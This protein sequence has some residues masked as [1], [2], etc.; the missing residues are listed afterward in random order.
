MTRLIDNV[1]SALHHD[2]DEQLKK[3]WERAGRPPALRRAFGGQVLAFRASM[4]LPFFK[5]MNSFLHVFP[6]AEA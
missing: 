2:T 3:A 6:L 1:S 5:Y 4:H